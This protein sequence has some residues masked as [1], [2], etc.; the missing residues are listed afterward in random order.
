MAAPKTKPVP[1]FEDVKK[2]IPRLQR[3]SQS[4][5]LTF[6][7]EDA[8]KRKLLFSTRDAGSV[9]DETPGKEDIKAAWRMVRAVEKEFPNVRGEVECVDEWTNVML[10]VYPQ[11]LPPRPPNSKTLAQ[12]M[13]VLFDAVKPTAE[14]KGWLV[15]RN[16]YG[17]V[18]CK[19][20]RKWDSP[21]IKMR[22]RCF[23]PDTDDKSK[24]EYHWQIGVCVGDAIV[25]LPEYEM[26]KQAIT[27]AFNAILESTEQLEL[28]KVFLL[29]RDDAT[30]E[31]IRPGVASNGQWQSMMERG[32]SY[33][34]HELGYLLRHVKDHPNEII[35]VK[36][37]AGPEREFDAE[38][39]QKIHASRGDLQLSYEVKQ[40]LDESLVADRAQAPKM[41][42]RTMPSPQASGE[43]E[44]ESEITAM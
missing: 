20:E 21:S 34:F 9:Y 22:L 1:S 43:D 37:W 17:E 33:A 36:P 23:R 18:I 14:Q 26:T 2:I 29:L 42:P 28:A 24:P 39:L 6:D 19:V 25:K 35:F 27:K 15:E 12:G 4:T 11:T 3:E 41:S 7:G 8:A 38:L 5:C 44:E 30:G 16:L 10:R 31:M 40:F 13:D 32:W